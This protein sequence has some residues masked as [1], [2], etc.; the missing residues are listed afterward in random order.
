MR[1][2]LGFLLVPFAALAL[3]L[4]L[5]VDRAEAQ[6][7]PRTERLQAFTG[8]GA[9]SAGVAIVSTGTDTNA[10]RLHALT[11]H[12]GSAGLVTIRD[13]GPG[14]TALGYFYLAADTHTV[15]DDRMLG[16]GLRGLAGRSIWLTI[17]SGTLSGVAR[18]SYD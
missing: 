9:I 7:A 10:P 13:G 12:C 17:A 1:R 6:S 11:V 14:G 3:A 4:A 16:R 15:L 5:P 8:N 18:C 2:Y